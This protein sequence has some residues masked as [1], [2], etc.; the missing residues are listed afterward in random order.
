MRFARECV[1]ALFVGVGLER[2]DASMS[3]CKRTSGRCVV[4]VCRS[5]AYAIQGRPKPQR[6]AVNARRQAAQ[7]KSLN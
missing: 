6:V 7:H 2:G 3:P 4:S 5:P 1:V